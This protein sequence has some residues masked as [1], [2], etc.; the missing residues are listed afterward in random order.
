VNALHRLDQPLNFFDDFLRRNLDRINE[1]L[2]L[3]LNVDGL[4]FLFHLF[5]CIEVGLAISFLAGHSGISPGSAFS[6][7]AG[8]YIFGP[9][10]FAQARFVEHALIA[11]LAFG[12]GVRTGFSEFF[13][14][15]RIGAEPHA[16]TPAPREVFAITHNFQ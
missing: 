16:T 11:A 9:L 8:R 10:N 7:Q 15:G 2:G 12:G 6:R 5:G 4:E 14:R 3:F 13:L 1:A